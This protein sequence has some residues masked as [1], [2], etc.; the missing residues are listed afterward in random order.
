MVSQLGKGPR[1]CLED[2]GFG[3]LWIASLIYWRELSKGGGEAGFG[4]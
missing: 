4:E 2:S 1:V 3:A